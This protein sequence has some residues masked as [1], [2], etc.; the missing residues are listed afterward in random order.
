MIIEPIM[1]ADDFVHRIAKEVAPNASVYA[2]FRLYPDADHTK[3]PI[4]RD[5][6][7]ELVPAVKAMAGNNSFTI[8]SYTGASLNKYFGFT[9]DGDGITST[10]RFIFA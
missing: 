3:Y 6:T 2:M 7:Y 8:V 1:Y 9:T 4:L 5:R 10:Y